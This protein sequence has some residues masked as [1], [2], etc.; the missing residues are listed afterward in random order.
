MSPAKVRENPLT[1]PAS[2]LS[3]SALEVPMA[4][5]AVPKA[6][7][8]DMSSRNRKS[9]QRS[10]PAMFPKTPV[11]MIAAVVRAAMP[12][13]GDGAGKD[14]GEDGKNMS[15]KFTEPCIKW[16]RK[17]DG[18]RGQEE[19]QGP[20]ILLIVGVGDTKSHKDCSG[21]NGAN[22]DGIK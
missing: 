18:S 1:A 3:S 4:W 17:A 16:Y 9:L 13:A 12:P 14:T 7:P 10:G 21:N 15:A 2:S 11:T 20:D 19:A 5:E 6:T 22:E 8:F